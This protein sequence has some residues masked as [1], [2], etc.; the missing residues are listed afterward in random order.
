MKLKA[1]KRS[2]NSLTAGVDEAG[3]GSWA[4]PVVAAAVIWPCDLQDNRIRDSKQLTPAMRDQLFSFIVESAIATG[5]GMASVEEIDSLGIGHAN[6]L[7]MHRAVEALGRRPEM[8]LV[9]GYK[10]EF[11][12]LPCEGVIKGDS[13][14]ICIA[15]ASIL[16]KVTRDRM[17]IAAGADDSRYGFEVHKGYGTALHQQSLLVHGPSALHR[18]SFEPIRKMME[19]V[20][21]G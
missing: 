6:K 2:P 3:R 19:V 13:V 20:A 8:V 5:V 18:K 14:Y 7:A 1:L 4:G 12:D 9:D 21:G 16:A 11:G 15:A 17:M 10:V